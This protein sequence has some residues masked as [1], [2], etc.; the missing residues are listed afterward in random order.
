VY[1]I[2]MAVTMVRV[3]YT[4]YCISCGY[5]SQSMKN[6]LSIVVTYCT[7]DGDNGESV[8]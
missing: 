3:Q 6:T 7:Y 5:Y 1:S 8:E 2:R 4:V